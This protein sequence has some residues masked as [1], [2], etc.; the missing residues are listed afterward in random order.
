[1]TKEKIESKEVTVRLPEPIINFVANHWN[2][3]LQENLQYI[4]ADG[5]RAEMEAITQGFTR[6]EIEK[7]YQRLKEGLKL[8]LGRL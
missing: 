6:T 7:R 3:T 1:M 8:V 5:V 4:V 2:G